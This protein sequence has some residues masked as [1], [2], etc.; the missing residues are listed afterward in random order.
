[1]KKNKWLRHTSVWFR[2]NWSSPFTMFNSIH[3]VCLGTERA[4]DILISERWLLFPRDPIAS[5]WDGLERTHSNTWWWSSDGS[6]QSPFC[7]RKLSC[8][9]VTA[10]AGHE[11]H[12]SQ[13]HPEPGFASR[14]A[15]AQYWVDSYCTSFFPVTGWAK[16]FSP[17]SHT[18]SLHLF[19]ADLS[20]SGICCFGFFLAHK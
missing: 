7:T 14:D 5:N 4:K 16:H 8:M 10:A 11:T 12:F 15:G 9:Q 18:V 17:S 20:P 1:M 3:E 13:G 6:L 2:P 19:F